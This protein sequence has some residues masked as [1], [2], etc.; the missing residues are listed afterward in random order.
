MAK[1]VIKNLQNSLPTIAPLLEKESNVVM[2]Y[3]KEAD[4]LYINF[5]NPQKADDTEIINEDFLVRKIGKKVIGVTI[6]HFTS[7]YLRH[8]RQN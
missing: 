4:V 7:S 2:N 5:G 8:T 3:D 6:L 1:T